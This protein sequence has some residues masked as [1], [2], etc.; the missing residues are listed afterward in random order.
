MTSRPSYPCVRSSS[1]ARKPASEAPTTTI[2][3]SVTAVARGGAGSGLL[4]LGVLLVGAVV[5]RDRLLRAPAHGLLDLGPQLLGRVFVEDVEEV[6]VSHLEHFRRGSH[7]EGVA[8]AEVEVDDDTHGPNLVPHPQ[9]TPVRSLASPRCSNCRQRR[10]DGPPWPP[11]GWPTGGPAPPG[12]GST[13]GTSA[14]C[15][16]PSPACR[17][18]RST[19]S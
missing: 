18:T 3:R 17:S 1:A 13:A 6:V 19:S 5:D 2:V 9:R 11:R 10:S 4:G 8:L 12:P 7:A 14:V 15:S 16:T